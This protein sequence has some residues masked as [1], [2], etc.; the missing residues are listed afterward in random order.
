[1]NIEVSFIGRSA[2]IDP[3]GVW[4]SEYDS[5]QRMLNA[6]TEQANPG[7]EI[8]DRQIWLATA[9]ARTFVG[10]VLTDLATV[11]LPVHVPDAIY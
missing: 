11:P 5:L 9:A 8:P 6:W 3:A 7:P 4:T 1:M 2:F 10:E